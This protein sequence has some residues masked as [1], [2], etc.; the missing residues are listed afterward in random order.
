MFFN[1]LK[2]KKEYNRKYQCNAYS[3]C[4]FKKL[5]SVGGAWGRSQNEIIFYCDS[6]PL[7]TLVFPMLSESHIWLLSQ[8]FKTS[9]ELSFFSVMILYGLFFSARLPT[10]AHQNSF[11]LLYFLVNQRTLTSPPAQ[12]CCTE[13]SWSSFHCRVLG[14]SEGNNTK[15]SGKDCYEICHSLSQEFETMIWHTSNSC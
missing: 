6:E 1:L 11:F 14:C 4:N 15:Y 3:K 13:C 5:F 7:Y 12:A 8:H 10:N 9:I 2:N